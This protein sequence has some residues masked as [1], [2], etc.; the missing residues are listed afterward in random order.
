MAAKTQFFIHPLSDVTC[1]KIGEGTRIWQFAVV[2]ANRVGSG[3]N[4]CSH[5]FI[6]EDVTLGDRVTVKNGSLI[7]DGVTIENDVFIGPNVVFANDKNPRSTIQ[8]LPFGRTV[9]RKGASIGASCVILPGVVI[10][11]SA[12]IGAGSTVTRDVPA[13]ST[14]VGSPARILAGD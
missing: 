14:V 8:R 13:F 1:S 2:L 5:V 7:Y 6:E 4:I 11:E 3:C 9:V 12:L 10:G